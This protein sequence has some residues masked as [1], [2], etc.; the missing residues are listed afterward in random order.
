MS[1]YLEMAAQALRLHRKGKTPVE[2]KVALALPYARDANTAVNIG[3]MAERFEEPRL[4]DQERDMLLSVA[5]YERDEIARGNTC[6]PKLKY[7]GSHM[8]PRSRAAYL[9]Y[10]R[11]GSHRRGEDARRPGTGL[12]LLN[13]Y[14]GYVRL[15]RA[16]WALVHLLEAEG[17]AK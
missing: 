1:K 4:T 17:G 12:A 11:L 13:P 3:E 14:N 10:K 5:A 15:T 6:A 8:W 16:G 9:A 2:I 7:A